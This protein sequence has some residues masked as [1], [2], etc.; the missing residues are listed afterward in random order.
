MKAV[1]YLKAKGRM[2]DN[3]KD[4]YM[5]RKCKLGESINGEELSCINLEAWHPEQAVEIVEKWA[6]E[7]P[8]KTCKDVLLEKFPK[9]ILVEEQNRPSFCVGFLLG[10]I[11]CENSMSCVECWNR[12]YKEEINETN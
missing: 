4:I 3:C 9:T 7:N 12:E 1:E 11:K 8:V 10:K 6:K 2:T 5:C